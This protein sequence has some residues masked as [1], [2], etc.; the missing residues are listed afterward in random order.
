MKWL[1]ALAAAVAACAES[2]PPRRAVARVAVPPASRSRPAPRRARRPALKPVELQPAPLDV[3]S[4]PQL[5]AKWSHP[6]R[7]WTFAPHAGLL[8]DIERGGRE[9]VARDA[10]TGR[11]RWSRRAPRR[12][13]FTDVAVVHR[14][15]PPLAAV[16]LRIGKDFYVSRVRLDNGRLG[17]RVRLTAEASLQV[18]E[19]GG[20]EVVERPA[21][22]ARLWNPDSQR[23]AGPPLAA[24]LVQLKDF[25]GRPAPTCRMTVSVHA[26][27]HGVS[28]GS[29]LEI[30]RAVLAGFDATG[31][32]WR[33]PLGGDVAKSLLFAGDQAVFAGVGIV[34]PST[35]IVRVDLVSGRVLWR[36][37][38]NRCATRD[39]S[40]ARRVSGSMVLLDECETVQA[41]DASSG[42]LAWRRRVVGTPVVLGE[43]PSSL[44]V[45][46]NRPPRVQWL[47]RDGQLAGRIALP[48][49]IA[50]VEPLA[51]GLLAVSAKQDVVALL[52][53]DGRPRWQ[54]RVEPG[55][56]RV[57][58][59]RVLVFGA[60]AV[61]IIDAQS[62]RAETAPF[63]KPWLVG[64]A[65][66]SPLWFFA[67]AGP[68]RV[69][70]LEL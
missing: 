52:E 18:G 8:C 32:S 41:F 49:A 7:A 6:A 36:R 25:R 11:A 47:K 4:L 69:V 61:S 31:I 29:Y 63:A 33:L 53:R 56:V 13:H 21:C 24:S 15:T 70:A 1:F 62:G 23:W 68:L 65:A 35:S 26:L 38:S 27:V 37:D 42:A 19:R 3:E 54:Y 59:G 39:V 10:E 9:L 67:A 40:A 22:R 44:R 45:F 55:R 57:V 58:D 43:P 28:V 50:R 51:G 48:R 46:N 12:A 64:H 60:R 2:A 16:V 66:G 17:Y 14:A 34:R 5:K 20:V 30:G